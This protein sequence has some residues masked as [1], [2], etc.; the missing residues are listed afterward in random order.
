MELQTEMLDISK[1][2]FRNAYITALFLKKVRTCFVF[3][4]KQF[5]PVQGGE[6]RRE[7]TGMNHHLRMN[8]SWTL[9]R[10]VSGGGSRPPE[11]S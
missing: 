1:H 3:I 4:R 6:Y 7:L 2:C 8:K 10:P 9:S 11:G 5:E